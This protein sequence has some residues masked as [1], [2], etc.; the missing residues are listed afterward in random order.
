MSTVMYVWR[1]PAA[2]LPAVLTAARSRYETGHPVASE[3]GTMALMARN[4]AER[5]GAWARIRSLL[6]EG[7]SGQ[8]DW[9]PGLQLF[10]SGDG[11]WIA[12]PLEIGSFFAQ[13]AEDLGL[14]LLSYDDRTDVPGS[15]RPNRA[16]AARLD[17]QIRAGDY[18]VHH[19]LD[20][21]RLEL[22]AGRLARDGRD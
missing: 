14:E 21:T 17:E 5:T 16:L 11:D 20:R 9:L 19:L 1:I 18:L 13:V 6:C 4:P 2:D 8:A 10:A 15:D 12:R 3:I 7:N 22:W